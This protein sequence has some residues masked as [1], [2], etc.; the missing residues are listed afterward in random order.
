[1]SIENMPGVVGII[2]DGRSEVEIGINERG[3]E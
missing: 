2:E 1:M 3:I